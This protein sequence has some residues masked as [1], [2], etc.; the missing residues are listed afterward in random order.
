MDLDQKSSN[1]SAVSGDRGRD[2]EKGICMTFTR[3]N[4]LFRLF[5][6][7]SNERTGK[8]NADN[9]GNITSAHR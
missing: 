6:V 8:K 2:K 5:C 1:V 4:F 7:S 3:K 9:N